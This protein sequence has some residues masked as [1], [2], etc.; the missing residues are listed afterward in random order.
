MY[1]SRPPPNSFLFLYSLL[2]SHIRS[3]ILPEPFPWVGQAS[4]GGGGGERFG[5][6]DV[7]PASRLCAG[8]RAPAHF[9]EGDSPTPDETPSLSSASWLWSLTESCWRHLQNVPQTLPASHPFGLRL[10]SPPPSP[11]SQLSLGHRRISST[12]RSS[13]NSSALG[14]APALYQATGGS[15][16]SSSWRS[17]LSSPAPAFRSGRISHHSRPSTQMTSKTSHSTPRPQTLAQDTL[18]SQKCHFSS[19]YVGHT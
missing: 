11:T 19:V 15:A 7:A 10:W 1:L 8:P 17:N 4:H 9:R 3:Q 18:L 13:G 14:L 16:N 2:Y 12:L 5:R 6:R